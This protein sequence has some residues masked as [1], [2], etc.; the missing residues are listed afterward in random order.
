MQEVL[1]L[2]RP[3]GPE[4]G[5]DRTQPAAGRASADHPNSTIHQTAS[6]ESR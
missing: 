3:T 4:P 2:R 6:E 5:L 1:I